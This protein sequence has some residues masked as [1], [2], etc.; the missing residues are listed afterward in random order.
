MMEMGL[1]KRNARSGTH[2]G[3]LLGC[4]VLCATSCK[5]MRTYEDGPECL[6]SFADDFSQLGEWGTDDGYIRNGPSRPEGARQGS[7]EGPGPGTDKWLIKTELL[8]LSTKVIPVDERNLTVRDYWDDESGWKFQKLNH[9]PPTGIINKLKGFFLSSDPNLKDTI[10]WNQTS[11]GFFTVNSAYH[12][13]SSHS[14]KQTDID[15]KLIW[16]IRLPNRINFF[17]WLIMHGRIMC[18]A[19]RKRRHLTLV[20]DCHNCR[21]VSEDIDHVLRRCPMAKEVWKAIM[22]P[23]MFDHDL[24]MD[25]HFWFIKNLKIKGGKYGFP[26]WNT[27]FSVI[28]WHIWKWRNYLIFKN[29]SSHI[30]QKVSFIRNYCKDIQN[31]FVNNQLQNF[32]CNSRLRLMSCWKKPENGWIAVN[33]DGSSKSKGKNQPGVPCLRRPRLLAM[34]R[35]SNGSRR[36]LTAAAEGGRPLCFP[37]SGTS[38]PSRGEGSG[39]LIPRLF[40]R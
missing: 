34:V 31:A 30:F 21:G 35:S 11:T 22:P 8:H 13:V 7:R 23:Q 5:Y 6:L 4:M 18:N 24:Q 2:L 36:G 38:S 40:F 14:N 32:S 19:E 39:A 26:N 27:A 37:A 9:H 17:L 16:S 10:L 1:G 25:W 33:V 15:W 12:L 20:D 29:E 28:C 3:R